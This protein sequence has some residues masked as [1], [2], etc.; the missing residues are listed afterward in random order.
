MKS[1]WKYFTPIGN[2]LEKIVFNRSTFFGSWLN[3]LAPWIWRKYSSPSMDGSNQRNFLDK[4]K[5]Q[6]WSEKFSINNFRSLL[7][8]GRE[9]NVKPTPARNDQQKVSYRKTRN[10]K[11]LATRVPSLSSGSN[12]NLITATF[13]W[14][15]NWKELESRRVESTF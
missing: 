7:K 3:T 15:S 1:L 2:I 10:L 11:N 13:Q 8:L 12:E 5:R 14:L 6:K 4:G 9:V